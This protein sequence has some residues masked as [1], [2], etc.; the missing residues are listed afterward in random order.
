MKKINL[1]QGTQN[2]LD[3]RRN[4]VGASD[5]ANIAEVKGA[6]K[7]RRDTLLEK[8]G[9][10]KPLTE[11]QKQMFAAGHEWEKVIR[12]S[13]YL[14][15]YNFAPAVVEFDGN[16]A[17]FASLDGLDE[18]QEIILEVKSVTTRE[19]FEQYK[20]E[21][22]AHYFAQVQWQMLCTGYKKVL[23]AYVYQG[24]VDFTLIQE[25]PGIQS[26]LTFQATKFLTEL[27]EIRSGNRPMPVQNL[28]SA[29]MSRLEFLK[30][31]REELK[32]SIE[33]IEQE[34]DQIAKRVLEQ[35]GA[36][37]VENDI[38][39]VSWQERKGSIA[40]AKIPEIQKLGESYLNSFRGKDSK[41]IVCKLK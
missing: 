8:L 26:E 25:D 29:D 31:S 9:I 17:F 39:S 32:I 22:P 30:H 33:M 19:R 20:E 41:F 15:M 5:I 38:L 23:L 14:R 11:F 12:D 7:S 10:E 13:Q 16:P 28:D 35:S 2:W 6:F 4:G 3:Y 36:D 24:E 40:Y 21:T 18:Q 37:K 1:E 27:N 34:I